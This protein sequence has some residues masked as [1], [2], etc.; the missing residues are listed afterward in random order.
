MSHNVH[1][2][3]I[4]EKINKIRWRPNPFNDSNSFI[5]G[6]WDNDKNSIRLWDFQ[7][8]DDDSDI[9]PYTICSYPFEGDV[10][11]CQVSS[12]KCSGHGSI[13]KFAQTLSERY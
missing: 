2:T 7:S 10:T 13:I 4:S 1:G 12:L 5:T 6:S 9:Y 3:F 8:G 11:E